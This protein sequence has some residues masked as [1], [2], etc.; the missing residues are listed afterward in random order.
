[1][2]QQKIAVVGAG[3]MGT[4]IAHVFA[5]AG[6]RVELIDCKDRNEADSERVLKDA[7]AQIEQNLRFL[8]SLGLFESSALAS[9]LGRIGYHSANAIDRL[10][11]DMDVVFE[12]V[13]EILDVKR[14]TYSRIGAALGRSAIVASTTSTFSANELAD[15]LQCPDRFLNTHWLN[16]AYLIPLVEVSPGERTAGQVTEQ[17]IDLLES[18]GKIPVQCAAS[19]GFIVPRIQALAMNEA[20]RLVEEGVASPEDIDKASKAGFGLRFAVLGLLE[21][22]DWGG[23]DILFYAGNY[24]RDSL[25]SERYSPPDIISE[26]M[27][28]G[29]L[30]MK[31]GKGFYHFAD[32]DLKTYQKETLSKFVDLLQHMGYLHPPGVPV[33]PS[34]RN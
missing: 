15:F 8:S 7:A 3:R 14:E 27:K 17:M 2:K 28:N 34:N 22:I 5:Y 11:P 13:P 25:R 4:G 19:P 32:R 9:I 6:H 20:A 1:M 33:L 30:G 31:T 21:F 16:P 12:A 23:G 10:L 26:N 24:L 18:M 29:H